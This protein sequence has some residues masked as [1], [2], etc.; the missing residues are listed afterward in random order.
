MSTDTSK[1]TYNSDGK[2]IAVVTNVKDPTE[3]GRCQIRI[4]GSQ[5][6][7]THIPDEELN[8]AFAVGSTNNPNLNGVGSHHGLLDGSMVFVEYINGTPHICGTWPKSTNKDG[9]Q[10]SEKG[11]NDLPLPA[12]TAETKGGNR[13]LKERQMS[14]DSAPKYD[15]KSN[16]EYASN[17]AKRPKTYNETTKANEGVGSKSHSI[18]TIIFS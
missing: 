7:K 12:R 16:T 17:E 2:H 8:W 18:G 13:R 6:D 5:E 1:Y 9:E 11:G 14:A 3:S 10:D 4:M 15:D